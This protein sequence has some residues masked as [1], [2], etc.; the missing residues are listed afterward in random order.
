MKLKYVI[1]LLFYT[2]ISRDY[3]FNI[4]IMVIVVKKN[5][6]NG[7]EKKYVLQKIILFYDRKNKHS[8]M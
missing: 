7:V 2:E 4:K 1:F 8:F 5:T 3:L 6:Q